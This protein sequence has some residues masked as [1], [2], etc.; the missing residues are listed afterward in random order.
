MVEGQDPTCSRLNSQLLF[1]SEGHL[2]KPHG[3]SNKFDPGHT[4][5]KHPKKKKK[6]KDIQTTF[7]RPWL[8]H[9]FEGGREKHKDNCK[10]FCVHA[11]APSRWSAVVFEIEAMYLNRRNRNLDKSRLTNASAVK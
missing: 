9:R 2:L 11:N 3:T 4:R 6:K 8:E 5:L 7:A 1:I 10:A